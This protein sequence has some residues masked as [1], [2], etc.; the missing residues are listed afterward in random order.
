MLRDGKAFEFFEQA[1]ELITTASID[2]TGDGI[3][4]MLRESD[5]NYL[6]FG[7]FLRH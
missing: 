5:K 7:V 2:F 3:G 1:S 4:I 6:R